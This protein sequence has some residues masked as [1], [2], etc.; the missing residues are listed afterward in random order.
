MSDRHAKC[1]R[2]NPPGRL[3]LAQCRGQSSEDLAP[4]F[5]RAAGIFGQHAVM[6]QRQ[7][8]P[9]PSG[10][11]SIV[12]VVLNF[13]YFGTMN[14]KTRRRG[15]SI[16]RYCPVCSTSSPSRRSTN[17]NEPPTWGSIS[18]R[19]ILP[20]GV[21]NNQRPAF[22]GSSQASKTRSAA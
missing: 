18:T 11:M 17:V 6:R 4:A 9:V 10:M 22:F 20:V 16:S 7:A 19:T 13:E 21:A 5:L 14:V 1:K 3:T 15:R 2:R 8:Q 12:T